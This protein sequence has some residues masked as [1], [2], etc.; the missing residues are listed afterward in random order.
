MPDSPA[1][2]QTS[3]NEPFSIQLLKA[4]VL[5]LKANNQKLRD[6]L[7]EAKDLLSN[8]SCTCSVPTSNPNTPKDLRFGR[9]ARPCFEIPKQ[10][11]PSKETDKVEF[12]SSTPLNKKNFERTASF[13]TADELTPV[14]VAAEEKAISKDDELHPIRAI[15][16]SSYFN[17]MMET[18][19]DSQIEDAL[20]ER[21]AGGQK[22][23]NR[24]SITK[25][26]RVTTLKAT[27]KLKTLSVLIDGKK[28]EGIKV[29]I[30]PPP[31]YRK[32][33]VEKRSKILSPKNRPPTISPSATR[34]GLVRKYNG[35]PK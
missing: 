28:V 25:D 16:D 20:S 23:G 13:F 10:Q 9:S 18:V 14:G 15:T 3:D 1:S 8:K 26:K 2:T 12:S 17:G 7:K 11:T 27:P 35:K 30:P 31:P 6:E 24:S 21:P 32:V 22:Q 19:S 4:E 34:S 5:S 33:K 29:S